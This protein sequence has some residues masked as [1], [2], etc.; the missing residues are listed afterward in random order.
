MKI[1]TR[2]PCFIA[3]INKISLFFKSHELFIKKMIVKEF[4]LYN[5]PIRLY[6]REKKGMFNE[7]KFK[8]ISVATA[9]IINK[10]Q[11]KNEKLK[12]PTYR[13][14]LKGYNNLNK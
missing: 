12:R 11:M 4:N 14:K 3:F 8:K 1:K 13:R 2:P 10:V 7:N 6:L 9:K 5:S